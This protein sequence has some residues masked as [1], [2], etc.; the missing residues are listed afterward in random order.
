M[1]KL[2]DG[3]NYKEIVKKLGNLEWKNIV[4]FNYGKVYQGADD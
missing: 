2:G 4:P 1:T 3:G